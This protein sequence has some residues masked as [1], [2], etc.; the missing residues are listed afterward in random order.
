M[1]CISICLKSVLR[2]NYLSLDI[3][4]PGTIYIYI[5]I[6]TWPRAWGSVV[7]FRSQKGSTSENV[8]ETLYLLW[9]AFIRCNFRY[10]ACLSN[11][12]KLLLIFVH[13]ISVFV[14]WNIIYSLAVKF[15]F[16]AVIRRSSSELN[17]HKISWPCKVNNETFYHFFLPSS[18]LGTFFFK[19]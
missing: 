18:K 6:Y 11:T 15:L 12:V 13:W 8:C 9:V 3:C 1:V 10:G 17:K 4:I 5:Y 2:Y 7:I 16:L 14:A 19:L